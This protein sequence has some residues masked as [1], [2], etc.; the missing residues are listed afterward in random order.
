MLQDIPCARGS[1]AGVTHAGMQCGARGVGVIGR[2]V[3]DV[4][5]VEYGVAS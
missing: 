3:E 4:I 2:T 1:A 5:V